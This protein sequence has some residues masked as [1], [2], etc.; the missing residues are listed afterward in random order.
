[1]SDPE[2]AVEAWRKAHPL[3]KRSLRNLLYSEKYAKILENT[4]DVMVENINVFKHQNLEDSDLS[5]TRKNAAA[6]SALMHKIRPV[7]PKCYLENDIHSMSITAHA[8]YYFDPGFSVKCDI[9]FFLFAKTVY[10]FASQNPVQQEFVRKAMNYEFIGCF[11]LTELGHGSNAKAILTQ[12][13]YD[14][15]NK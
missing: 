11:G 4:F 2:N 15:K 6:M 9:T 13:I 1:M 7:D 12:A 8:I 10:Y 14:K 3:E 5:E